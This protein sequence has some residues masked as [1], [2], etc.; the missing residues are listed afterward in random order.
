ME[1]QRPAAA[2]RGVRRILAA[3]RVAAGGALRRLSARMV[4]ED[5]AELTG[6]LELSI[7]I[8]ADALDGG[9]V[10]T[11]LELPG[12]MSQGET[13][14]EALH[15]AVDAIGGVLEARLEDQP[16]SNNGHTR[17]VVKLYVGPNPAL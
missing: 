7:A 11:C 2:P 6:T 14:E 8:E 5:Q 15:N 12:C 17:E 4:S 9:F 13:R 16:R 1:A 10:A 3:M